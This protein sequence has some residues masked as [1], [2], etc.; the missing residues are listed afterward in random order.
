MAKGSGSGKTPERLFELLNKA[1][2]EKSQSAVS[3]E[4]GLGLAAINRYVKGVGE[5]TTKTLQ[6]FA[7]YFGVGVAELRGE[8]SVWKNNTQW[9]EDSDSLLN[10]FNQIISLFA[11]VL[12]EENVEEKIIAAALV[13]AISIRILPAAVE[14]R[15][16]IDDLR[17]IKKLATE[18]YEKFGGYNFKTMSA[19]DA[20]VSHVAHA[21]DENE[22]S[23]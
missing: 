21:T 23:R 12:K 6:I 2:A 22:S 3:R 1:V 7:D 19:M 14:S 15:I 18:V 10:I 13:S 4:T 11:I 16:Q 20:V 8:E 5:P 9:P 17:Y